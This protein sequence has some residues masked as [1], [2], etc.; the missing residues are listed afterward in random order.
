MTLA[1]RYWG[2]RGSIPTPTPEMAAYGGNTACVELTLS[3]GSQVILDAGTG[4]RGLG[5]AAHGGSGTVHVLLTHLHLDHIQ[6]LMFFAPL[7][8]P[9]RD[10]RIYGPPALGTPLLNRLG[11][12]ISAPLAPVE[13]HEL[14]ARV[15]F[16]EAHE[17]RWQIG[18]ASVEAGFVNHRGPTLGYRITDGDATVT[19][20]P[21]HEP[22]LGQPLDRGQADWISGHALARDA[23]LLIHDAQYTDAE[24]DD[25]VGWGH[26]RLGDTIAFARRAGAERLRLFHHDPLHDD[27]A[28][29]ALGHEAHAAAGG[30]FAEVSLAREQETDELPT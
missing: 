2:A 25:H 27:A 22:A 20:L 5:Q 15:S 3:D 14:P 7:F 9:G 16:E 23:D 29:D 21:D 19:Y 6:G 17:G 12:Y 10:V 18:A 8:E 13:I 26:S 30:H 4:I 11:R 24:Y 1:V 28:L